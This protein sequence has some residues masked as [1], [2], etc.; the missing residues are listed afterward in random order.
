MTTVKI[1]GEIVK[2]PLSE[3]IKL[4]ESIL[5]NIRMESQSLSAGAKA[6]LAD[7]QNDSEL[8]AFSVLDMENF[9]EAQ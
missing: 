3:R 8:T 7:Y 6:L 1:L 9:Y 4:A 5:R 2:L